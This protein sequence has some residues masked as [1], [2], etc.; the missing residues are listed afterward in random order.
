MNLNLI[1]GKRKPRKIIFFNVLLFIIAGMSFR[2]GDTCIP[3]LVQG[4]GLVGLPYPKKVEIPLCPMIKS[5]CCKTDDQVA[6]FNNWVYGGEATG[7]KEKFDEHQRVYAGI[8]D[9]ANKVYDL[10]ANIE[11]YLQDR[12]L[13][14]CKVLA[15]RILNFNLKEV[16]PKLKEIIKTFQKFMFTSYS[17]FYCAICDGDVQQFIIV[18]EKRMEYSRKFC[19]DIIA[20]SL[21][22]LLYFHVHLTKYLNL[23]MKFLTYCDGNGSYFE[24]PLE[25]AL[26]EESEEKHNL[27]RCRK[28]RN[29]PDWFT[30][31]QNICSKFDIAEFKEFF[32]P[33]LREFEQ[34]TNNISNLRKKMEMSLKKR[35]AI[36]SVK[37][38]GRVRILVDNN[39]AQKAEGEEEENLKH[40]LDEMRKRLEKEKRLGDLS[41]FKSDTITIDLGSFGKE[42]PEVGLDL[43]NY[44]RKAEFRLADHQKLLEKINSENVV[45]HGVKTEEKMI[46]GLGVENSQPCSSSLVSG[47]ALFLMIAWFALACDFIQV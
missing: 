3:G 2:M 30:E 5:S 9:E 22:Y 16:F 28:D 1:I 11:L 38:T 46:L 45:S 4:Y 20:N 13:S 23:Q 19:R 36:D 41:V 15:G 29:K 34:M 42:F 35:T 37:M 14:N 6:I 33:N 31:C 43:G 40:D 44:G 10:A 26:I 25:G 8:L 32:S 12:T 27:F 39:E 7:L 47:Y 17:G 18:Q 21:H 24:R